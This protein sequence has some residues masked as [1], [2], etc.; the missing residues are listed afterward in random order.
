MQ[1]ANNQK[2]PGYDCWGHE[3]REALMSRHAELTELAKLSI[4]H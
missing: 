2:H 1:I 4:R 3:H